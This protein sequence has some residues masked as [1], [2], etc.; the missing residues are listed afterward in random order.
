[1]MSAM[2]IEQGLQIAL[3]HDQAG[4]LSE[5]IAAYG[6][7]L[8]QHPNH[9][10]ALHRLGLL[11]RRRDREDLA[12]QL[13]QQAIAVSPAVAEYHSDLGV[14]LMADGR[15]REAMAAFRQA[16]AIKPDHL[17]AIYNLGNALKAAGQLDE[18][19]TEYRRA[20]AVS[21]DCFQAHNN[22]AIVLRLQGCCDQAVI[23]YRDALR[24]QPDNPEI[25]WNLAISLL[26]QGKL[27]EGWPE[28][29]WRWDCKWARP[30]RDLA[31]RQWT[32][33]DP[34]GRT[35]LLHADEGFG[36]TIQFI[37]YAPLLAGRGARVVVEC[38]PELKRLLLGLAGA[39]QVLAEGEPL[40]PTDLHCPL[41]SLPL[42]FGTTL[43]T[44]P[45]AVAYLTPDANSVET[46]R[47]RLSA[48]PARLK[49]GLVWAGRPTH[50]DDP[51][52]SV[53]LPLLAPLAEVPDV[54]YYSLQKGVAAQQAQNP[55]C[56]W[57]VTDCTADL[58]DF[59]DTAALIANLDLVIAVD[60]AVAHLAGALGKPVWVLLPFSPDW[61]W[62][63]GRSDSPW[64]PT[65]RLFRQ[66]RR[67]DWTGPIE[68]V[69]RELRGVVG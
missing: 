3:E 20:L 48:D 49:V 41:L 43:E 63:L 40:P 6:L 12:I 36:D 7:V 51:N 50:Q 52:R 54:S 53:L 42:A 47:A 33:D 4:R 10:D 46:W 19:V 56:G 13:I 65:L 67:G 5:A 44:I 18:A 9:P 25:H 31:Q 23:A 24:L 39:Q 2:T 58:A 68:E 26:L 64:Y 69:A 30:R 28:L 16:A 38:Q 17:P 15:L 59:A 57:R 8:A 37:R 66:P 11:A 29:E 35:I 21:S 34:A 45:A 27:Q 61:R 1:M 60:T 62:L 32:G 22:L 55:P 14:A